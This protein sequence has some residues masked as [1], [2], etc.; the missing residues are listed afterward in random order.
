MTLGIKIITKAY[1]I[2]EDTAKAITEFAQANGLS[3]SAA[4]RMIV[5]QWSEMRKEYV[6][7]PIVEKV[8]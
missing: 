5:C 1:S 4:L 3:E 2:S 8:K 7:V 6:R